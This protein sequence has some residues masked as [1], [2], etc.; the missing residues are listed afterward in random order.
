MNVLSKCSVIGYIYPITVR[1]VSE[2]ELLNVF[3]D[4][5]PVVPPCYGA[6]A[7]G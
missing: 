5:L 3:P 7:A 1:A 6:L 4:S 2:T